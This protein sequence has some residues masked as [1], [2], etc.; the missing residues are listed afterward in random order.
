MI[1]SVENLTQ[2]GKYHGVSHTYKKNYKYLITAER[3]GIDRLYLG[4][5]THIHVTTI[6]KRR[7][8]IWQGVRGDMAGIGRGTGKEE[9]NVITF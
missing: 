1:V 8:L 7:L 2:E 4:I 5:Y 3:G 6:I 9:I